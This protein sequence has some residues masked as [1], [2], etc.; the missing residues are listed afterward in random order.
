MNF[1]LL[2][3]VLGVLVAPCTVFWPL[4]LAWVTRL[5]LGL[6]EIGVIAAAAFARCAAPSDEVAR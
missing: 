3:S 2:L 4:A 6:V 5:G 1:D